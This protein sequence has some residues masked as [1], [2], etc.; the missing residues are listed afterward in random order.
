MQ[1]GADCT[2]CLLS[3]QSIQNKEDMETISAR[4]FR[5]NQGKFLAA[6]LSGESVTLKSRYGK[7]RIIP[8]T[9]AEE[10]LE[11]EIRMSCAE[12]KEHMDGKMTLPLAKDVIF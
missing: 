3:L 8:V 4:D 1:I 5:S 6:A 9:E 10:D 7:F 2:I 12:V 11:R